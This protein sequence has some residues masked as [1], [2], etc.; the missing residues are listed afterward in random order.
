MLAVKGNFRTYSKNNKVI[1]FNTDC[2]DVFP[3]LETESVDFI[4]TDP[5][6]EMSQTLITRATAKDLNSNFGDWDRFSTEW[7]EQAYRV[8]KPD[9][10]MVVF[11]PAQRYETLL[12]CCEAAGF[13]HVQPWFFHRSNPA[14]IFRRGLQWAVE[15]MGYYVKGKHKLRIE[16][17]GKCHNIFKYPTPMGK[18]RFH[19][20]QKPTRLMMDIIRYVSDKG[21][22]ILDCFHGS[23]ATGLAAVGMGRRYIGIEKDENYFERSVKSFKRMT[24]KM[25]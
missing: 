16:N 13:E 20:T 9:S 10:G 24:S 11:V 6:Y 12:N 4:I 5:P 14:P 22:L 1:I 18:D 2:N 19:P 7:V 23:G 8:L 3:S 17:R 21:D 15:H 25:F